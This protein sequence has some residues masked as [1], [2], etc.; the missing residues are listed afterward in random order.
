[1]ENNR[2]TPPSN[3][4][5]W[6]ILTTLFCCLPLGIVSIIHSCKVDGLYRDGQYDEAVEE[7]DKAKKYAKWGAIIGVVCGVLYG[8]WYAILIILAASNE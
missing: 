8:V 1:M 4:L 6:A 3:N 2:P 5:V 7:A